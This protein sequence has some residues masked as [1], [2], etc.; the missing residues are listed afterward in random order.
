MADPFL[1]QEEAW[2][3]ARTIAPSLLFG[4]RKAMDAQR[5]YLFPLP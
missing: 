4:W 2:E 1:R 5:V 3:F